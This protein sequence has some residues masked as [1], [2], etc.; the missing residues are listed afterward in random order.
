MREMPRVVLRLGGEVAIHDEG[1]HTTCHVF[2]EEVRALRDELS[3]L[4]GLYE[5]KCTEETAQATLNVI[6][7][8]SSN[9]LPEGVIPPDKEGGLADFP[10]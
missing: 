5:K 8:A 6:C 1:G 9:K 10:L 7:G 4:L 3:A 2:P